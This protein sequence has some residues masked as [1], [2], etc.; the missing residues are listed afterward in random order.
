[1][2]KDIINWSQLSQYLSKT[3]SKGVIRSNNIPKKYRE[4][5]AELQNYIDQWL[6]NNKLYTKEQLLNEYSDEIRQK[7][8]SLR[9]E[10]EDI[11]KKVH[12]LVDNPL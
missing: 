11:R 10:V 3:E 7:L 12:K 5:V 4:Q 9:D 1:M 6:N 2:Q 8:F